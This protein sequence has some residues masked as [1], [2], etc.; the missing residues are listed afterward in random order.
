MADL[1]NRLSGKVAF[2][3]GAGR[4]QG[5][6]YAVRLASEGADVIVVDRCADVESVTYPMS[7]RDDLDETARLVEKHARRAIASVVD[8]RATRDCPVPWARAW[9]SSDG[10]TSLSP[11]P[12]S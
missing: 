7:T 9:P 11:T 12:A 1:S 10:S 6:A 2:V 8:V 3:T 4:G 5:R